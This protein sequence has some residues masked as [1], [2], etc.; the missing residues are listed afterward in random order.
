LMMCA[1]PNGRRSALVR[2]RPLDVD[3]GLGRS[4]DPH[5]VAKAVLGISTGQCRFGDANLRGAVMTGRPTSRPANLPLYIKQS[6]G[7]ARYLLQAGLHRTRP[8]LIGGGA[9]GRD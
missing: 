3:A 1:S 8:R 6:A 5:L 2:P 9:Y 4:R 7:H